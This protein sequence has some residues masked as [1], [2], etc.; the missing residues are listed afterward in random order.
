[1]ASPLSKP[2]K[3]FDYRVIKLKTHELIY[4]LPDRALA[5]IGVSERSLG[6]DDV[7]RRVEGGMGKVE[8]GVQ[9]ATNATV[10]AITKGRKKAKKPNPPN[11]DEE[12]SSGNS[13]DTGER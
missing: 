4:L 2:P 6:E 5:W 11:N 3:T 8:G 1:V 10:A 7:S 9:S 12:D 13:G